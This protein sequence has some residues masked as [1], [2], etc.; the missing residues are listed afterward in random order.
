MNSESQDQNYA[1]Y[2]CC[3]ISSS[4]I[5]ENVPVVLSYIRNIKIFLRILIIFK[6]I[7]IIATL[8]LSS[9]YSK[10]LYSGCVREWICSVELELVVRL[11]ILQKY[12]ETCHY[13]L[14]AILCNIGPEYQ[15]SGEGGAC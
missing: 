7:L 14:H 8:C 6:Y 10:S 15:H 9:L 12:L 2:L 1:T 4:Y 5:R 13:C 11:A 3:I